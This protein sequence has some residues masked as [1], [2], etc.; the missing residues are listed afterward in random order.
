MRRSAAGRSTTWGRS[1]KELFL[2]LALIAA[3][4][5]ASRAQ[6]L[7][8]QRLAIIDDPLRVDFTAPADFPAEQV[9]EAIRRA[10][11]ARD[12]QVSDSG[13]RLELTRTIRSQ[14]QMTVEVTWDERGYVIRYLRSVNL[15]YR[16]SDRTGRPLRAIHRNYNVWVRDLASTI[17][18]ELGTPAATSVGVATAR[19]TGKAPDTHSA[20]VPDKL[21][22]TPP[23]PGTPP[24]ALAFFGAWQGKWGGDLD[25]IL[26]VERIE[27]S[28]IHYVYSYGTSR[29]I[30]QAGFRRGRGAVD[31][32]GILRITTNNGT[33]ISY[34]PAKDGKSLYGQY[35]QGTRVSTGVFARRPLPE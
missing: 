25:H 19:G 14:H 18:V 10:A 1:V 7:G 20:P 13:A 2:A 33:N 31:E 26:I 4:P 35:Q 15:L 6:D 9:R 12:W 5:P 29:R 23:A 16:D 24:A 32:S 3:P 28:T 27:G 17:N 34:E 8:D 30:S 11:A 22:I 21:T